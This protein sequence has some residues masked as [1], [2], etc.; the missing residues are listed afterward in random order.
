[1]PKI[2]E[3]GFVLYDNLSGGNLGTGTVKIEEERRPASG[4]HTTT[5]TIFSTRNTLPAWSLPH[6]KWPHGIKI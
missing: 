2:K 1:L 6:G 5:R 4:K 3:E